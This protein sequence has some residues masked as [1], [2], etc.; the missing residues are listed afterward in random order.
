MERCSSGRGPFLSESEFKYAI[1]VRVWRLRLYQVERT[2]VRK[3]TATNPAVSADQTA[4]TP[5]E[6]V[7]LLPQRSNGRERVVQI[8]EAAAEVI[9]ERGF[10]AATMKEIAERS[11]TKIGSLYR[12][13]F[14]QVLPKL[15]QLIS[16]SRDGAYDYLPRS[17]LEFPDDQAMT[18]WKRRFELKKVSWSS[19]PDCICWMLS[20]SSDRFSSVIR[21]AARL[22]IIGSMA[23]RTSTIARNGALLSCMS[24]TSVLAR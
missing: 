13:Y 7:A 1:D 24:S 4:S 19:N 8:M 11:N 9:Y 2:I 6:K 3:A 5:A 15:G 14:R 21:L 22:L 17:V 20:S 10:E 23:E 18:S 12:F 16:R